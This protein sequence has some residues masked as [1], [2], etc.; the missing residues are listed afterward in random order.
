V[1]HPVPS[2]LVGV[3]VLDSDGKCEANDRVIEMVNLA[4]ALLAKKSYKHQYPHCWRSKTRLMF[5]AM[6]QWFIPRDKNNLREKMQESIDDINW[7]PAWGENRVRADIA[8]RSDSCISRQRVWG[9]PLPAFYDET[10]NALLGERV[11]RSVAKNIA[12]HWSGFWFESDEE[13]LLNGVKL[14]DG[15]SAEKLKKCRDSLGVWI[16]SGH[17]QRR[18]I[19]KGVIN[20]ADGFNRR[21][22]QASFLG[23][24]LL[25]L[26]YPDP[27][28]YCRR[29]H[30]NNFKK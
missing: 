16:D 13:T 19:W 2:E 14:P 10:R 3:S 27:W 26:K 21:C 24:K 17:S 22:G 6:A 11:I 25:H 18:C 1:G 23:K 8:S 20:I 7:V 5:R 30:E 29:S 28:F 9:I 12:Q 15:F 4:Q